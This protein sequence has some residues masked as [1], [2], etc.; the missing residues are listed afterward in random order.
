MARNCLLLSIVLVMIFSSPACGPA[1]ETTTMAEEEVIFSD[2]NLEATIGK[3]IDKPEGPIYPSELEALTY[4]RH[5]P[6]KVID[7]E[8]EEYWT[9]QI[10]DLTGLEYCTNLTG[11][12]LGGN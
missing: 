6:I 7:R 3:A 9:N 11:L 1:P 5:S 12:Y 4:L 8:G 10:T 2:P